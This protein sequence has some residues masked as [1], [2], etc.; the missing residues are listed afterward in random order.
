MKSAGNTP[1][2]LKLE[3]KGPSEPFTQDRRYKLERRLDLRSVVDAERPREKEFT[4]PCGLLLQN[5][6]RHS[7]MKTQGSSMKMCTVLRRFF[8]QEYYEAHRQILS[9]YL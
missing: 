2:T 9:L 3:G 8:L 5:S 1:L 4:V 7:V 6:I